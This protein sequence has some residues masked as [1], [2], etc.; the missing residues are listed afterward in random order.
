MEK[1]KFSDWKTVKSHSTDELNKQ[2]AEC[3]GAIHTEEHDTIVYLLEKADQANNCGRLVK[4][5]ARIFGERTKKTGLANSYD[6]DQS[7]FNVLYPN[8][9]GLALRKLKQDLL[10]KRVNHINNELERRDEI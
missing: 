5:S 9:K 7:A 10:K 6:T 2:I 1:T 8:D 3:W 4:L